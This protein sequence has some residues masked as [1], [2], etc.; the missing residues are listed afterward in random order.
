MVEKGNELDLGHGD[1][2][3]RCLH[4]RWLRWRWGAQHSLDLLGTGVGVAA[5]GLSESCADRR[6]RKPLG[7]VRVRCLGQQD[8]YLRCIQIIEGL[9][10]GE[11]V[12]PYK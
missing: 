9:H 3:E 7:P 5:V 12:F 10:C 8:E 6:L 11:E 2:R 4:R 1:D